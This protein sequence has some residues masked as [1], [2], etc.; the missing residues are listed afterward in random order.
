ML[1]F[2]SLLIL[3]AAVTFNAAKAC[4]NLVLVNQYGQIQLWIEYAGAFTEANEQ[5]ICTTFLGK[6]DMD[7]WYSTIMTA[8][9]QSPEMRFAGSTPPQLHTPSLRSCNPNWNFK[10]L[11]GLDCKEHRARLLAKLM[12]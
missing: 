12:L 1:G 10:D 7:I 3:L 11:K 8:D 4:V 2:K 6:A 9:S 5:M